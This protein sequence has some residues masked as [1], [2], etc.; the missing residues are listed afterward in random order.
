MVKETSVQ[1]SA[2]LSTYFRETELVKV[3]F[4]MISARSFSQTDQSVNAV[5]WPVFV[6]AN[7]IN[8]DAVV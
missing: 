8:E 3:M 2:T 1:L 4:G 5:A 7:K 6:S